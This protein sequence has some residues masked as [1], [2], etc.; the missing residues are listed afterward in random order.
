LEVDS[1]AQLLHSLVH[2]IAD[3]VVPVYVAFAAGAERPDATIG[4]KWYYYNLIFDAGVAI[5]HDVQKALLIIIFSFMI[6][7]E[8]PTCIPYGRRHTP[9]C[10]FRN[11]T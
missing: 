4:D 6:K 8:E 9:S 5:C 7:S 10:R 2:A 3:G 1:G 11:I